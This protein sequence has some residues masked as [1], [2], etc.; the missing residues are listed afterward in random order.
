MVEWLLFLKFEQVRLTFWWC[1]KVCVLHHENTTFLLPLDVKG[2]IL[3]V[4]NFLPSSALQRWRLQPP[5][6]FRESFALFISRA[7]QSVL[8]VK[9]FYA[10]SLFWP[11]H[12]TSQ[13]WA[14]H[15]W[16]FSL[17]F[18]ISWLILVRRVSLHFT[19]SILC[20]LNAMSFSHSLATSRAKYINHFS[21][22]PSANRGLR[23]HSF[24]Y[25]ALLLFRLGCRQAH[26]DRQISPVGLAQTSPGN[27]LL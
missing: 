5:R 17:A 6:P 9:P 13:T 14:C 11:L 10:S 8:A 26:R 24:S 12:N 15:R 23:S 1:K 2:S 7:L 4:R 20:L 18:G 22:P 3:I 19:C 27:F 21:C 16:P 25:I